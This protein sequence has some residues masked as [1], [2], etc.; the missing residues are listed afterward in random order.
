MSDRVRLDLKTG[1]HTQWNVH[2]RHRA[3]PKKVGVEY[4]EGTS[5]QTFCLSVANGPFQGR[6]VGVEDIPSEAKA[7]DATTDNK[8]PRRRI[9]KLIDDPKKAVYFYYLDTKYSVIHK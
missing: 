1:G 3:T 8:P 2:V 7:S 5:G 9:L 4:V 6:W